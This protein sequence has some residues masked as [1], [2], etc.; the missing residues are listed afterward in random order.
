M[1][2]LI[3][4]SITFISSLIIFIILLVRAKYNGPAINYNK[5]TILII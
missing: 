4:K 5:I 1:E 3:L 2:L